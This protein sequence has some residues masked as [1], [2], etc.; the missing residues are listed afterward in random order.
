MESLYYS[1]NKENEDAYD[2][3]TSLTGYEHNFVAFDELNDSSG[4]FSFMIPSSDQDMDDVTLDKLLTEAHRGQADY[5]VP[6]GMSVSQSVCRRQL[7]SMD[8]GNVMER[9]MSINQLILVSQET[10]TRTV[11][12]ASFLKTPEL[13]KWSIDQGNLMSATAQTHSL[14]L[15]LKSKDKPLSRNIAKKSAITNSKQLTQK[16]SADFYEKNYDDRK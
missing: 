1:A 10:R 3:A 15:H 14:G 7:C 9:E 8:Q 16:K 5:C 11:F 12:T 4:S 6:G 2:V 13:R